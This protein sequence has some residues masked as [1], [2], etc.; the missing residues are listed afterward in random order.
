MFGNLPCKGMEVMFDEGRGYAPQTDHNHRNG[1]SN[2]GYSINSKR[3]RDQASSV[4]QVCLD[5]RRSREANEVFARNRSRCDTKVL[6]QSKDSH[7][8]ASTAEPPGS[9]GR[10]QGV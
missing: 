5:A 6:A 1:N 4:R 3:S 9:A 10:N 2:D 8:S 7:A